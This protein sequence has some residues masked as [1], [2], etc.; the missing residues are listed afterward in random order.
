MADA[1]RWSNP[2]GRYACRASGA[3]RAQSLG[4][5]A[6][7][8]SDAGVSAR[9][10]DVLAAVGEH[11]TNAEIAARLFISV[12][13]VESHVS[14]LLR[15]LGVADR[16]ELARY[17][18]EATGAA[19]V[20]PVGAARLA[21]PAIP[22]PLTS[23]VGRAAER[24]ALAAAIARHRLVTAVGPGGVGKTRLAIAV[25][26]E[27][28]APGGRGDAVWFVDLV[29][30]T[31]PAM[32]ADGVG[33]VLGVAELPGGTIEDA[34][35]ARLARSDALIVLDNCEHLVDGVAVF[36]ERLLAA[37]PQVR[38][39]ATS[40]T[41]LMLPFEHVFTV[42]GLSLRPERPEPAGPSGDSDG[43]TDGH[44]HDSGDDSTDDSDAVALF[45]ERARSAAGFEPGN[46]D[47]ARI[48]RV[49]RSLDGMALAIELAAARLAT[50]GLDGVES[51]LADALRM[52]AGGPRVD[53]R[54]S[55][56]RST[57]DWSYALLDPAAQALLRR[58]SVFAAPFTT[59]AAAEVAGFPPVDSGDAAVADGLGRLADNSLAITRPGA[60]TRYRVLETIRQYGLDQL[61]RE[62]ELDQVR[63]RHVRWCVDAAEALTRRA[64]GQLD[65]L[66]RIRGGD[67]EW[68]RVFDLVADDKRAALAWAMRRGELRDDAHRLALLLAH[69]TFL[70]GLP[71]EAQRRFEEAAALTDDPAARVAALNDAAGAALCRHV[72]NDAFRLWRQGADLAG[73]AGDRVTAAHNLAVAAT[74]INRGPGI[75]ANVPPPEVVDELLREAAAVS[76]GDARA[77]SGILTAQAFNGDELDPLTQELA[78]RAA[79]LARRAGNGY[80]ESAALDVL[81]AVHL[82]RGDVPAAVTTVRARIDLLEA[83]PLMPSNGMEFS[84]GYAMASEI[85]LTAGDF[86]AARIHA[87]RLASL[88]FVTEL[89]HIAT[90]RRIK[91][92]AMAGDLHAV[93]E[94]ADRF[95]RGWDEAGRPVASN[96]AGAVY[97]VAMV[98]GLRG[99]DD[100]R[101]EWAARTVEIGMAAD[102]LD[103]HFTGYGPTFDA[104]VSLHRGDAGAAVERL[105]V[106]PDQLRSWF[107]GEWRTWYAAL[108]AEA[109]V[110]AGHPD[111]TERIGRAR[112][113]AAANPV[114]TAMLERAAALAVGDTE[115]VL[116]AAAA[117]EPTGCRYQLART[118]VLAGGEHRAAGETM[119]AEMGTA[120]P[121]S[122]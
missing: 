79:S 41:R 75:M 114:A 60:E 39:L 119:L 101:A 10:A 2:V 37:C 38:V 121:V 68:R 8:L 100:A 61:D 9:E 64:R 109:A 72:G 15:K 51:G 19:G 96:L 67:P 31:D 106:A 48:A 94:A 113:S 83:M 34:V 1:S 36:V 40:R 3:I 58:V 65:D 103:G 66:A 53:E 76:G 11:L 89:D 88:P 112:L 56:L 33:A 87:D 44:G 118:L 5:D 90:A 4:M 85:S 81:S 43:H 49:C 110:L 59:A 120:P 47:M 69:L 105:G 32:V 104:I 46:G 77:E 78:E 92:D 102:R 23:F 16:R 7:V 27:T 17:A 107:S 82:A 86:E 21:A 99:D 6:Q 13:T 26:A 42:P 108:W 14:S 74:L 71:A 28:T 111:A 117:L 25:A 50:L 98:H 62:G 115:A 52:L 97:A 18:A 55:S 45:L 30:I 91:V 116:A 93:L 70:R 63:T 22:A 73:T 54:H 12:R 20:A 80:D 57:I 95:R 122:R 24:E 35:L 29:P 84:D